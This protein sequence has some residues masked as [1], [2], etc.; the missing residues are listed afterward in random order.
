[1]KLGSKINDIKRRLLLGRKAIANLNSILKSR[2]IILLTNVHI[3]KAMIFPVVMYGC[4][5]W[6]IKEA[7]HW[8]T[9]A[10]KLWCWRRF[11][12]VPWTARRSNQSILKKINPEYSLE[13]LCRSSDTLA[14]WSKEPDPDAGKDWGQEENR[15]TE[16]E[17]VGWHR[18]LSGHEFEETLGNGKPGMLQSMGS[19]RVGHKWAANNI[20]QFKTKSK[21]QS[22]AFICKSQISCTMSYLRVL[23]TLLYLKWITKKDPLY[24]E[25]C[26]MLC[27]ILDGRGV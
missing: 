22:L 8:R 4:E 26:S 2:D 19:Q 20:L 14:T 7:E 11:L 15:A 12:R 23:Y 13:G 9:D 27:G 17:M 3:V 10:F 1:M 5:R 6:I 16:D 25:L 21:N 18:W 24:R